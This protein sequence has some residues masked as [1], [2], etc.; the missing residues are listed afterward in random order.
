MACSMTRCQLAAGLVLCCRLVDAYVPLPDLAQTL[1][2]V[3]SDG[4]VPGAPTAL[5][6]AA[7]GASSSV[8][9]IDSVYDNVYGD[10]AK[11]A[12]S[13]RTNQ[14]FNKAVG[15]GQEDVTQL[16]LLASSSTVKDRLEVG[17]G[18]SASSR[19]TATAPHTAGY[20]TKGFLHSIPVP[21]ET[22]GK[23]NNLLVEYD[24]VPASSGSTVSSTL[25]MGTRGSSRRR[26]R[27]T[28]DASSPTTV[29][30]SPTIPVEAITRDEQIREENREGITLVPGGRYSKRDVE[31]INKLRKKQAAAAQ[32]G[33]KRI[34]PKKN[35]NQV[36]DEELQAGREEIPS[37][38]GS[39]VHSSSAVKMLSHHEDSTSHLQDPR[40]FGNKEKPNSVLLT[41]S[42]SSSSSSFASS[43]GTSA[44]SSSTTTAK[45]KND[46]FHSRWQQ[47]CLS[48]AQ[49]LKDHGVKGSGLIAQWHAACKSSTDANT[50]QGIIGAVTPFAS[51][52]SWSPQA[53][54]NAIGEVW[55][56]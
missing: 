48:F 50:C 42:S 34:V 8:S 54:C 13:T 35:S 12:T 25:D 52:L 6:T 29:D 55:L 7:E 56:V 16:G 3:S 44:S 18:G 11:I 47:Q 45:R 10:E 40:S 5:M 51:N 53:V 38:K 24:V 46:I 22:G 33:R 21:L 19:A 26:N 4:K 39:L 17:L 36:Q 20:G 43:A 14:F 9:K 2:L 1:D 15:R 41:T 31:Y 32:G 37:R 27:G 49:F 28:Q 30:A 23:K